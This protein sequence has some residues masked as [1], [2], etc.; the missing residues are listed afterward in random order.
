[1]IFFFFFFFQ[2]LGQVRSSVKVCEY[3]RLSTIRTGGVRMYIRVSTKRTDG[4][5]MYMYG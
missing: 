4:F 2:S 3:F 1:M 5:R